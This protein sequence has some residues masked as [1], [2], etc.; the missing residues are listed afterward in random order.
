[1]A[2]ESSGPASIRRRAIIRALLLLAAAGLVVFVLALIAVSKLPMRGSEVFGALANK[3]KGNPGATTVISL[4]A[5][6]VLW[7][8]IGLMTAIQEWAASKRS[9]N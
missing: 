4:V 7:L 2:A 5:V 3:I 8:S 1:M 9:Q 6:V